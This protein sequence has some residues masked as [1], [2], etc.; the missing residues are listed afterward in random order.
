LVSHL[1]QCL[2]DRRLI[3]HTVKNFLRLSKGVGFKE[4][5]YRGSKG[6]YDAHSDLFGL[7][8]DITYSKQSLEILRVYLLNFEDKI[9]TN[10]MNSVFNSLN[11]VTS[12]LFMV[13]KEEIKT[14]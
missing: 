2:D 8:S 14:D 3:I 11:D 7:C 12:E 4:I 10:F 13:I 9:C 6:L 1:L 5:V